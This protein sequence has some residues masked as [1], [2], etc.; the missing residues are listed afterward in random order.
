[1]E[2]NKMENSENEI[3]MDKSLVKVSR[4]FIKIKNEKY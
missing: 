1:M 3:I 2:Q 4:T